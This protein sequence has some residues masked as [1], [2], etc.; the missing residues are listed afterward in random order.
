MFT[1]NPGVTISNDYMVQLS[2]TGNYVS[3]SDSKD[4]YNFRISRGYAENSTTQQY[5][6]SN[7]RSRDQID[8]LGCILYSRVLNDL[9]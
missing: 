5:Y 8:E 3:S 6:Y 7:I 9:P 4:D 1:F 2:L